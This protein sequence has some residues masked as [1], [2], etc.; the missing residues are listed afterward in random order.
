MPSTRSG[1]RKLADAH[2]FLVNSDCYLT[3]WLSARLAK[4]FKS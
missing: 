3:L 1:S 4:K 2:Q